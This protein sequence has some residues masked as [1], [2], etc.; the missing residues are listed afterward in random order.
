[1]AGAQD[2]DAKSVD[3]E[4][5]SWEQDIHRAYK[6]ILLRQVRCQICN[7]RLLPESACP[8]HVEQ[9]AP[10]A[11]PIDESPP[12][13]EGYENYRLLGFG[14]FSRI[15]SAN[16]TNSR[17]SLAIKVSMNRNDPRFAREAQAMR[18]LGA[19]ICP[20][21]L[22]EGKTN[23]G[24]PY[25]AMERLPGRSLGHW[26]ATSEHRIPPVSQAIAFFSNLCE[27]VQAM[28][29]QGLL[30]R[31]L[32]PENIMLLE[33]G[34]VRLLDLGLA[35]GIDEVHAEED[36]ALMPTLTQTGA[37]LGTV[38]Y[39][40]PEQSLG[41]RNLGCAAD[42]YSLAVIAFEL[43]TGRLPFRGNRSSILQAHTWR[44]PPSASHHAPLN[45]AVD[46]ALARG[47]AKDPR[48]RWPQ[49]TELAAALRLEVEKIAASDAARSETHT[50]KSPSRRDM[51][52]LAVEGIVSP[53]AAT[54][55]AAS[56]GGQ[57]AR[58]TD[59]WVIIVF[60]SANSVKQGVTAAV[61]LA[62][63]SFHDATRSIVHVAKL[64]ARKGSRGVML[65][66][67][68][69]KKFQNWS[70]G[71]DLGLHATPGAAPF[72]S[73]SQL[74][75]KKADG[76]LV[77]R[78]RKSAPPTHTGI[79]VD[80]H[81]I[82][83]DVQFWGRRE[84]VRKLESNA[85]ACI[86]SGVPT[87]STVTGAAGL[88]KTHLARHLLPR[89]GA[90]NHVRVIQIRAAA[91]HEHRGD[92]LLQ[93]LVRESFQLFAAHPSYSDV[94]EA[95]QARLPPQLAKDSAPVIARAIEVLSNEEFE[96]LSALVGATAIRQAL[97]R[98]IA[99]AL[100]YSAKQ[101]PL[102]VVV[103]DAHRADFT[104]LDAIE[105]ATLG[106]AD[107][108]LWVLALASPAILEIRSNWGARAGSANTYELDVLGREAALGM[109][110]Q[111]LF[112]VEF[113]PETTLSAIIELAHG[114]PLHLEEIANAL[115][116]NGA[117]RKREGTDSWLLASDELVRASQ[118]PLG[119]R[120]AEASLSGMREDLS[121]FAQL[122]ATAGPK[123]GIAEID[124]VQRTL[125][126]E[127]GFSE[128]D[129]SAGISHLVDRKI[130]KRSGADR[131]EFRHP[132]TRDAL[133]A[134]IPA[135][136]QR[137]LH[138]AILS[139]LPPDSTPP[140][141]LARHAERGGESPLA[142]RM[143]FEVAIAAEGRFRYV[144][145]QQAFSSAL[146]NLAKSDDANRGKALQGRAR[147]H[148]CVGRHD[149]A[150]E[151]LRVAM[152]LAKRQGDTRAAAEMLL[153]R[154]TILDWKFQFAESAEAA[155]Q[156]ATLVAQLGDERLQLKSDLALARNLFREQD[157]LPS[158]QGFQSAA[159]E[160]ERLQDHTTRVISH[161]LLGA[162]LVAVGRL[163]EARLCLDTMVG[164]SERVGDR[165]HLAVAYANRMLVWMAR[166]DYER[167]VEDASQAATVANQ[168]GSFPVI[169]VSQHSKAQ[170]LLWL[171]RHK[172]AATIAAR[173]RELQH[174]FTNTPDPADTLLV[175]RIKVAASDD[176]GACSEEL[177][178]MHA[179]Y[180]SEALVPL[181]QLQCRMLELWKEQGSAGAWSEVLESA[182]GVF[183]TNEM[184][185]FLLLYA[186]A[187]NREKRRDDVTVATTMVHNLV[188][189][190]SH[191]I[192]F[193][194]VL[195]HADNV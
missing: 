11:Q 41:R 94:V 152:G 29:A 104:T 107:V 193:F 7:R 100:V 93:R 81:S 176:L 183:E 168:I 60:A 27:L 26:L 113:I 21:L 67:D 163:D 18:T 12:A 151:D 191:W 77:L 83:M 49:A 115:K 112:P 158:I 2:F 133:E 145:A 118:T 195:G 173:A 30:H 125:D 47:L 161:A 17:Q 8:E 34:S 76:R 78:G 134:Q 172:E 101:H 61:A 182:E 23:E 155:E 39:I 139:T 91:E 150:L 59:S 53:A 130:L 131:F 40:A 194:G 185:E 89:I 136:L 90:W 117:I 109:L 71:Y 105:M 56:V 167:A 13:I 190:G 9:R 5:D 127:L 148:Y 86:D 103:D 154:S 95:C 4:S 57:I 123:L 189:P 164:L 46:D 22:A 24:Y 187:A 174:R 160:A 88:G 132:M 92:A 45:S 99:E 70:E 137:V 141:Q 14:G 51:A 79:E 98:A 58:T 66:G 120:L 162:A 110:K 68:A 69:I 64:R 74:T 126:P 20:G 166:H 10:A 184:L 138:G 116:R 3:P 25:I 181:H 65:M 73:H 35:R 84:I 82:S 186:R 54:K 121:R 1:M 122:C 178:Y 62:H 159:T 114:I 146:T 165:L 106:S 33:D 50:R 48:N 80:W 31:D 180:E 111:L 128:L 28:H 36:Q 43:L 124:A 38:A 72:V 129:P 135:A 169:W 175:A 108:P 102:A 75:S 85:R 149:D 15:W 157:F 153:E 37:M 142:A 156:A 143:Y 32:K 171:G 170:L 44:K 96:A 147:I 192:G 6:V 42:I 55:A 140:A 119:E 177:T 63:E 188:D 52:L 87:L 97:A 144:E 179:Q 16:Q 19:G